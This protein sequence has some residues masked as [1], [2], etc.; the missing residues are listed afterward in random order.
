MARHR[1][2]HRLNG[3]E[4]RP[5]AGTALCALAD[6]GD[7]GA[8]GFIYRSGDQL[9]AG[10][11]VRRGGAVHGWVDRC[12]HAGMPLAGFG[13]RYLTREGDLILCASHGALFRSH[14]GLCTSGP[15]AGAAL[16]PWPVRLER[17]LVMTV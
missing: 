4:A 1:R 17:G 9:F 3:E 2:R 14:D 5:P 7:P 16:R 12:P 11:V 13:D 10:F 15:C 6:I 8:K